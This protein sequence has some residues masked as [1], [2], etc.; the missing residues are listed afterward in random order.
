[1]SRICEVCAFEHV[2]EECPRCAV[3]RARAPK[4]QPEPAV[5]PDADRLGQEQAQIMAGAAASEA[6]SGEA[7]ASEPDAPEDPVSGRSAPAESNDERAADIDDEPGFDVPPPTSIAFDR[8]AYDDGDV[9]SATLRSLRDND[10]FVVALLGYPTAGKTWF[11]NRL[12]KFCVAESYSVTP[13]PARPGE[14]V[15]GTAYIEDHYFTNKDGKFVLID[16]PGERFERAILNRFAT[17][18]RLL[19]V[20]Q[21]CRAMIVVLPTDEVLFSGRAAGRVG[22][23]ARAALRPEVDALD[24]AIPSQEQAVK[25]ARSALSKAQKELARDKSDP[26]LKKVAQTAARRLEGLEAE[27][28]KSRERL[29]L[30]AMADAGL[31]LETF[32]EGIGSLAAVASLLDGGKT[33]AEVAGYDHRAIAAHI[34]TPAFRDWS[35]KKPVFG[36]LTKADLLSR[37]DPVVDALVVE[38]DDHEL[39]LL[40]EFDRDPLQTVRHFRPELA[41]QFQAWFGWSK[42]DF[43]T[44]FGGHDGSPVIQY[45]RAHHGVWAVIEWIWWAFDVSRWGKSDWKAVKAAQWM[46]ARRDGP[47]TRRRVGQPGAGRG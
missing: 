28:A 34:V 46:R 16:I 42:F 45:D 2:T 3:R 17:E 10:E 8:T 14:V 18:P 29:G 19:E 13:P 11:M 32:I 1:M 15:G 4:A 5:A 20:V 12:K 41:N 43:V 21:T 35:Q 44:A 36:A 30:L 23:P 25:R 6:G 47:Q 22:A 37:E 24:R 33:P 26:V 9:T 40:E 27:L 31:R 38:D 7:A 39:D